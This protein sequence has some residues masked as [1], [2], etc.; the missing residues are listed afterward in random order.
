MSEEQKKNS[1]ALFIHDE[2]AVAFQ[3]VQDST[4]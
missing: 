2:K 3:F 1:A 4:I